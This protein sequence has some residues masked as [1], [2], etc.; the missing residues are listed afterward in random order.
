[1]YLKMI[2]INGANNV[3]SKKTNI[4]EDYILPLDEGSFDI[5]ELVRY[6]SVDLA[7]TI[8]IGIQC[9]GLKGDAQ[10]VKRTIAKVN[11]MKS[12]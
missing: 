8:P 5:K 7:L 6:V 1:S 4:W 11:D 10:L 2:S 12:Y 9:F 3:L